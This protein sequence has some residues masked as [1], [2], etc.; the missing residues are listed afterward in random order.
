MDQITLALAKKY[1]DDQVIEAGSVTPAIVDDKIAAAVKGNVTL[2][3]EEDELKS[4]KIGNK[5][6]KIS[7]GGADESKIKILELN[8]P[9]SEQGVLNILKENSGYLCSGFFYN[10]DLNAYCEFEGLYS[11]H[12]ISGEIIHFGYCHIKGIHNSTYSIDYTIDDEDGDMWYST[13]LDGTHVVANPE[14]HGDES[15]LDTIQIGDLKYKIPSGGGKDYTH[16]TP[17]TITFGQHDMYGNFDWITNVE[18]GEKF[19]T[20]ISYENEFFKAEREKLTIKTIAYV[21]DGA[22]YFAGEELTWTYPLEETIE[23]SCS[24]SPYMLTEDGAYARKTQFTPNEYIE[25][26]NI[27]DALDSL[28]VNNGSWEIKRNSSMYENNYEVKNEKTGFY[29]KLNESKDFGDFYVEVLSDGWTKKVTAKTTLKVGENIYYNGDVVFESVAVGQWSVMETMSQKTVYYPDYLDKIKELEEKIAAMGGGEPDDSFEEVA[30]GTHDAYGNTIYKKT[31]T[32][33]GWNVVLDS[34]LTPSIIKIH[35]AV[36][37]V[38]KGDSLKYQIPFYETN[39]FKANVVSVASE[40]LKLNNG[41]EVNGTYYVTVYYTYKS[42]SRS[43]PEP[44]ENSDDEI[45]E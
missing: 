37:Y 20:D 38:S 31:W 10:T 23:F 28:F 18:T 16:K 7:E 13:I 15:N 42:T 24:N 36:G 34:T 9:L 33:D 6:F 45:V 21:K 44:E 2:S 14:M 40:G 41:A 8:S 35:K 43:M 30:T 5:T 29:E 1:T 19:R 25:K 27:Q 11:G 22:T 39:S 3:G 4:L 26:D 17:F 32:G 12:Q